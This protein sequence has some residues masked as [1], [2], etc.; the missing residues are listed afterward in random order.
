MRK[1]MFEEQSCGVSTL[2]ILI[3]EKSHHSFAKFNIIVK[4]VI[5]LPFKLVPSIGLKKLVELD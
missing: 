5:M 2:E 3:P 4:V 1:V